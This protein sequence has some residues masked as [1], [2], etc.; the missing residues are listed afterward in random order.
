MWSRF[1]RGVLNDI[2]NYYSWRWSRFWRWVGNRDNSVTAH[3]FVWTFWITIIAS[4]FVFLTWEGLNQQQVEVR[5]Q[6]QSVLRESSISGSFFIGS[7]SLN[8]T[9]YYITYVKDVYGGTYLKAFP[10]ECTVVYEEDSV[11]PHVLF[12]KEYSPLRAV[13]GI[14][15]PGIFPSNFGDRLPCPCNC[16]NYQYQMFVPEGTVIKE[17]RLQ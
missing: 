4:P 7:G 9:M 6:M 8:Q 3:I 10:A 15:P 14:K 16:Q 5:W 13:F 1:W 11:A 17:F 2:K 12:Y